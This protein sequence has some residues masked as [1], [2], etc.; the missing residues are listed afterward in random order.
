MNR[1]IKKKKKTTPEERDGEKS[2]REWEADDLLW[3]P[4][5]P[6]Y[7]PERKMKW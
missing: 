3:R 1:V 5:E 7:G 6:N 2:R 4:T